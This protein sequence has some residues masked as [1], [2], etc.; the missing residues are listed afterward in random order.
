[1]D[2]LSLGIISRQTKVFFF[3]FEELS[4]LSPELFSFFRC[5]VDVFRSTY[6]QAGRVYVCIIVLCK[7][8]LRFILLRDCRKYTPVVDIDIYLSLPRDLI[9]IPIEDPMGKDVEKD[10]TTKRLKT[11]FSPY[12]VRGGMKRV[13]L[14]SGSRTKRKDKETRQFID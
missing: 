11:P 4:A 1:M 3:S 10:F 5:S 6:N 13:M 14:E 12:L 8:A 2:K 9:L 7:Y